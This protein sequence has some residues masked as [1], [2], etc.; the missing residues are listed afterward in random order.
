[1]VANDE[2]QQARGLFCFLVLLLL[3]LL[4][5]LLVHWPVLDCPLLAVSCRTFEAS[6]G[7]ARQ[8]TRGIFLSRVLAGAYILRAV[9]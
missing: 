1:M 5:L 2:W 4:L 9:K 6:Q 7:S 8:W 3:L